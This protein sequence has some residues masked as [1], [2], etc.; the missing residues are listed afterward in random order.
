MRYSVSMNGVTLKSRLGVV[1]GHWKWRRSIDNV[2]FLL[3]RHCNYSTI[4]YQFRV[5]WRWIISWPEIWVRGH[6]R[7]FK[8]VPF[9]SLGAVSYSRSIVTMALSCIIC[10]IWRLIGRKSGN[11]YIPHEF[12]APSWG[13]PVRI[14]WKCLLP[15]KLEWLGYNVAKK[16]TICKAVFIWYQNVTDIQ[17]DRIAI[18]IS[19]V[20]VLTRDKK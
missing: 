2:R 6:S 15:V 1:Q 13:D 16:L 5:I 9:K 10:D 19:R 8:L 4:L 20:S 14:L 3:I 7:S 12:S 11:F 17:T 18:S